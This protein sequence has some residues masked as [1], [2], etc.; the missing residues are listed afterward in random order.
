MPQLKCECSKDEL[1]DF[2]QMMRA[3]G[4][5]SRYAML[6]HLVDEALKEWRRKNDEREIRKDDSGTETR[7][8][9][10]LAVYY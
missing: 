4:Y 1:N 8:Q 5:T 10:P 7:G 3:E 2:E 6:K 9:R